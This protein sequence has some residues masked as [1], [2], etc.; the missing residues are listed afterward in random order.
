MA[1]Y[2]MNR[3]SS[4]AAVDECAAVLEENELNAI[5]AELDEC[6][7]NPIDD[8]MSLIEACIVIEETDHKMFNAL[9]EKDFI[10]IQN[11]AVLSEA[12][13]KEANDKADATAKK[14]LGEKIKEIIATV[15]KAVQN[16]YAAALKKL[17]ALGAV[18]YEEYINK[19]SNG[20]F[21]SVKI[22]G[23]KI[24]D[25]KA[26]KS[27]NTSAVTAAVNKA[28]SALNAA[29]NSEQIKAAKDAFVEDFNK[30]EDTEYNKKM[31]ECFEKEGEYSV[32]MNYIKLKCI[33]VVKDFH[34][35]KAELKKATAEVIKSLK[36][37]EKL[38]N[39]NVAGKSDAVA[40]IYKAKYDI[41][42]YAAKHAAKVY[43]QLIHIIVL[44][45]NEARKA[46]LAAVKAAGGA[47]KED[48][49]TD[50]PTMDDSDTVEVTGE[51][52]ELD[53]IFTEALCE[54]CDAI[55]AF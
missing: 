11:E 49:S 27:V 51:A 30:I 12:D 26:A 32:D 7:A 18:K 50:A 55:M 23:R 21:T 28:N 36:D 43:N 8:A 37:A 22:T 4:I 34:T 52:V 24:K 5:M 39:A 31:D 48:K 54:S 9:I 14:S 46:I 10:T 41:A 45:K 1:L 47:K 44:E 13:A 35:A 38:A 15:I 16:A 20:K 29:D 33:P 19:I 3:V 40:E 53:S 42:V 2:S 6:A 25:V 17:D